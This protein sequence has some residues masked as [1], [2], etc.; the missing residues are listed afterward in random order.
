MTNST[1]PQRPA[2]PRPDFPL[3]AHQNGRWAKK[4]KGK[5]EYFGK[6]SDDPKGESAFKLWVDNKDRLLAGRSMRRGAVEGTTVKY[7][8]DHF[9]TSKKRLRTNGELSPRTFADYLASCKRVAKAFGPTTLVTELDAADFSGLRAKLA[10]RNGPHALARQITQVRMLFKYAFE[11]G[12][13]EKPVMMG[14]TF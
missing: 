8:C 9:L 3:F 4:V 7:L 13:I 1:L 5:F 12:L 6:W 14:T 11:N 2:K 10:R